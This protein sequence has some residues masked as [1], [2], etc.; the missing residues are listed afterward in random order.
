MRG[1]CRVSADRGRPPLRLTRLSCD[2]GSVRTTKGQRLMLGPVTAEYSL[3]RLLGMCANV[4]SNRAGQRSP[5]R[6]ASAVVRSSTSWAGPML[7]GWLGG[8]LFA[9]RSTGEHCVP[10]LQGRSGALSTAAG[11]ALH[12]LPVLLLRSRLTKHTPAPS[13]LAALQTSKGELIA[14]PSLSEN[15]FLAERADLP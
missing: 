1:H 12:R 3:R 9:H 10:P 5:Q 15:D 13:R 2:C 11:N 8:H 7:T 4:R 14:A 6:A